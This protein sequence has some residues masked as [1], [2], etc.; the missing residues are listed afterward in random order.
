MTPEARLMAAVVAQAI[1]DAEEI[2]SRAYSKK[3]GPL[4]AGASKR[5]NYAFWELANLKSQMR[6]YWFS[7]V[8]FYAGVHRDDVMR[9]IETLE[10]RAKEKLCQM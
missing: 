1:T 2:I 6:A 10:E 5:R 4:T 3:D 8:C 9:H 7:E